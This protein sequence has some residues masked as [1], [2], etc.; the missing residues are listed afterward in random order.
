MTVRGLTINERAGGET[1]VWGL[2][3]HGG[4]LSVVRRVLRDGGQVTVVDTRPAEDLRA[5]LGEYASR[6][7]LLAET[8]DP[9]AALRTGVT[10]VVSPAIPPT[11]A[12]WPAVRA[13]CNDRGVCVTTQFDILCEAIGDRRVLA[14]TGSNGKSTAAAWLM[15]VLR[16]GG[17]TAAIGGNFENGLIGEPPLLDH[18]DRLPVDAVCVLE[19]SSFQLAV[20]RS[21][22]LRPVAA[23]VLNVRPNHLDWHG[24]FPKYL[25]AKERLLRRA[26]GVRLL[27]ADPA[28]PVHQRWRDETR[29]VPIGGTGPA[30]WPPTIREAAF[31]VTR[32]A[33]EVGV[34]IEDAELIAGRP[35]LPHRLEWVAERGGVQ[36]LDD[37]AATTPEA[38]VSALHSVGRNVVLIIGGRNKGFDLD[39]LARGVAPR[40]VAAATIGETASVLAGR[41]AVH[42]GKVRS[43]RTMAAAVKWAAKICPAEGT[44][45]LSPGMAS[46]DLFA[47]YRARGAAFRAA[48]PAEA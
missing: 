35:Q 19:V 15:A 28:D 46:T 12:A 21:Q 9:V 44:V 22:T 43:H 45:L 6:I 41:I 47:D 38:T 7:R 13:A 26:S 8:S 20:L 10:L 27:P 2:G 24:T 11:H 18:V 14:V 4:G 29:C 36:F 30:D 3:R 31:V 39:A 17:M 23:A 16:R 48:I 42:G 37:S 32:L 34:C 1:I 33:A 25:A 5:E 40:C